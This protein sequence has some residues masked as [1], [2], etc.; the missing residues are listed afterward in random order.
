ME[1]S[2]NLEVVIDY[3]ILVM[4]GSPAGLAVSAIMF[5]ARGPRSMPDIMRLKKKKKLDDRVDY[6][7]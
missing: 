2:I 6:T 7:P 4:L 3:N 5:L 1:I